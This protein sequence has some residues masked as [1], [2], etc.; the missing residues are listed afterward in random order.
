MTIRDGVWETRGSTRAVR[1]MSGGA[2]AMRC[3]WALKLE[4]CRFD[5]MVMIHSTQ[6]MRDTLGGRWAPTQERRIQASQVMFK[7]VGI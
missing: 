5:S 7:A 4:C 3:S 6:G 1:G 2:Q